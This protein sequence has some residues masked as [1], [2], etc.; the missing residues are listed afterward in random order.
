MNPKDELKKAAEIE[1]AAET[2][3]T[4]KQREVSF[5][6]SDPTRATGIRKVTKAEFL[7]GLDC[8]P[9]MDDFDESR[10]CYA[11]ANLLVY[12]AA[13][14]LR[15]LMKA[16]NGKVTAAS[17]QGYNGALDLV[18]NLFQ[19][20][21]SLGSILSRAVGHPLTEKDPVGLHVEHPLYRARLLELIREVGTS[22]RF[23]MD[24]AR[25]YLPQ[26]VPRGTFDPLASYG[27]NP[28]EPISPDTPPNEPSAPPEDD[29]PT[30][31]SAPPDLPEGGRATTI[32]PGADLDLPTEPMETQAFRQADAPSPEDLV[33]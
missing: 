14:N 2:A 11:D 4:P 1:Q 27:S 18:E 31:E 19:V 10:T 15:W 33:E 28:P 26:P 16:K 17:T 3:A 5:Y 9:E 32:H 23:G 21:H 8:A 12:G 25:R 29:G 13:W 30:G 7:K 6:V 20:W 22:S 24:L